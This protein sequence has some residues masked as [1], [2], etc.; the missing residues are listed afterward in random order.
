MYLYRRCRYTG[1]KQ[2]LYVGNHVGG[3]SRLFTSILLRNNPLP[4]INFVALW[5]HICIYIYSQLS[6][7]RNPYTLCHISLVTISV[8]I[9]AVQNICSYLICRE[10]RGSDGLF[11]CH[12][13]WIHPLCALYRLIPPTSRCG[14]PFV[15]YLNIIFLSQAY[16]IYIQIL[17]IRRYYISHTLWLFVIEYLYY[18]I[19]Y[20]AISTARRTLYLKVLCTLKETFWNIFL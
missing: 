2:R 9:H 20:Y 15:R 10:Y 19:I 13:A 7:T 11:V 1:Y 17:Y 8:R 18:V 16:L 12:H 6:I 4:D 5:I 3:K 14:P